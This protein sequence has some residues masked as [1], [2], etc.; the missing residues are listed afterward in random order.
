MAG[1]KDAIM[2]VEGGAD[3]IEGDAL[4]EAIDLAHRSMMPLIEMQEKL[5][6]KA[7]KKKW[8][9]NVVEAPAELKERIRDALVPD[10][11]QAFAIANKLE[12]GQKLREVY[13]AHL[14][15]YADSDEKP[16]PKGL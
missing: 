12:R 13:D 1:S 14:P 9:V 5:A 16:R 10:L 3:F 11:T 6:K 7:G 8:S 15:N 2:M 4:I